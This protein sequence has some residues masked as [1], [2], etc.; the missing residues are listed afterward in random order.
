MGSAG[1]LQGAV[2]VGKGRGHPGTEC[3]PGGPGQLCLWGHLADIRLMLL[4]LQQVLSASGY[5][6]PSTSLHWKGPAPYLFSF[7]YTLST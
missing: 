6:H 4:S 5:Q 2:C 1:G 7:Y 3:I